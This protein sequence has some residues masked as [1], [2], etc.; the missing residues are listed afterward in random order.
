MTGSIPEQLEF[1]VGDSATR[2]ALD[3]LCSSVR[4]AGGSA[5]LVGGCVRD[6]MLGLPASDLDVEIYGIEADQL[7]ELLSSHFGVDLVGESF[8]VIRLRDLPIDVSL[9]RRE[10]KRG[11]GHRGFEIDSDPQMH[12]RE[13]ASRRD[14]TINAIALDPESG[15][16]F[17]PFGGVADL[18]NRV[19]RH[20]T[21]KFS[22][23]PLRVL[24][25]MQFAAR[26]ELQL[27]PETIEL[28]REIE[29]EGLAPE[30]IF[31]EWKK[32]ILKGVRPSL[33]LAFLRDC[34]WIRH[35]PELQALIGCEQNPR[36]HPEGDVWIHT[37]HCMDVFASE[38]IGIEREDLIVGLAVLCHDL[39]KPATTEREEDGRITARKHE[40]VGVD[41]TRQFLGRLTSEEKL[42]E[43]IVP[44]VACHLAPIRLF[45]SDVGDAAIRRLARQ[46]GRIDRLVRV[47]RA[48]QRG[49]P[50]LVVDSFEAGEWLLEHARELCVDA[51]PP[52]PLLMGRH[53]I[54]LGLEPGPRFGQVLEECFSRQIEGEFDSLEAGLECARRIIAEDAVAPIE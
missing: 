50:P 32:L 15:R 27:A 31:G 19:L 34:G 8:G 24:R 39:G 14:F 54:E 6:A 53:L 18:K 42:I 47:S 44:L 5:R 3:T 46:V 48:D 28:C 1:N 30:R 4:A 17:D 29:P 45:G 9:P 12:P 26:F 33:G 11:L 10:S 35:F 2:S 22:E 36:W 40:V 21:E 20:T 7:I 52:K 49:R 23:D 38:R 37:L 16:L 41:L 25:G 13:A 51:Q 43:E